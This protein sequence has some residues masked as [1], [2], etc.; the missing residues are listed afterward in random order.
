MRPAN[1]DGSAGA[2]EEAK[3]IVKHLRRVWPAVEIVPR[4]DFGFCRGEIM[5][6]CERNQVGSVFGL[7]KNER[8][9]KRVNQALK[10]ACAEWKR[11]G[12]AACVFGGFRYRTRK[13]WTRAPRRPGLV[14]TEMAKAQCGTIRL[15][16]LKIGAQVRIT[17]CKVWISL[18]AATV[19]SLRSPARSI[20]RRS[21]EPS[22]TSLRLANSTPL[23]VQPWTGDLLV[24]R[25]CSNY[26]RLPG[27]EGPI[28]S[29]P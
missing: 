27:E 21:T 20:T 1:I 23:C 15:R 7:G 19:I 10:Q 14:G 28:A 25:L 11:T 29:S 18:A 9:L 3:R 24:G 5:R 26:G 17:V 2:L 13:N 12:K 6:W 22:G 8:L 4:G 16:L